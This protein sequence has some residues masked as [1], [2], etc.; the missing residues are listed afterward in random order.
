MEKHYICTGG[1][2]GESDKPGVC[3]TSG[4]TKEGQPFTPCECEDGTHKDAF[5]GKN[6]A[7]DGED[8]EED[9]E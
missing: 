3:Q 7:D 8:D 4:C 2:H 9:A 6:K 5:E 1:C